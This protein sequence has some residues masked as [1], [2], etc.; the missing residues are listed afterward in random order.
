MVAPRIRLWI[1]TPDSRRGVIDYEGGSVQLWDVETG[2][3][4]RDYMGHTKSVAIAE[5]SPDGRL[6]LTTAFEAPDSSARIW[7]LATGR[8]LL[9]LD[10]PGQ[11]ASGG[12]LSDSRHVLFGNQKGIVHL[13][14]LTDRLIGLDATNTRSQ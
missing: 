2:A 4:L 14:R 1:L 3:K 12:W 5:P 11:P 10:A 8:Q 9:K 6:L 7:D 13:Y